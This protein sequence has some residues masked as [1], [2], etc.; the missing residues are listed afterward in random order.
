MTTPRTVIVGGGRVG[1]RTAQLLNSRGHDIVIIEIDAD[2]VD[3]LADDYIGTVIEGDATQPDILNQVDLER[4]DVVAALTAQ[5]GTNL[6]VCLAVGRLEPTIETV[7]RTE[8]ENV[9][10]YEE[11]VD[12]VIFPENAG[13]RVAANAIETDVR[14]IEEVA[15]ALD[16]LEITVAEGAPV[17][18]RGLD[19]VQLPRGCIVISETG[20]DRIAGASTELQAGNTYTVAVEPSVSDEIMN[21][22]RSQ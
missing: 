20:G 9:K 19:T 17:D 14:S 22:F 3:E 12:E 21:L 13:A 4:T 11:Y 2:L 10:Q 5:T 7:M 8:S 15:G 18:G 1:R 16:I 6:A